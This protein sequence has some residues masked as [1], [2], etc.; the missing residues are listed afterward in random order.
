MD[1]EVA[2][3][4]KL[5]AYNWTGPMWYGGNLKDTL[6]GINQDKAFAKPHGSTHNIY[7]LV[8]HM[9][10]WRRFTLEHLKGN[11]A[12]TVE[13]NSDV[14]WP[15]HYQLNQGTWENALTQLEKNQNEL[16]DALKD[17]KDE[18]LDEL[19][20]GKKFKWYVLLHGVLHH[21]IYHSAQISLLKK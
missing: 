3:I 21:D 5:L 7:E 13:L 11:S 10:C 2:R 15:T 12:Y 1:K 20:P 9:L 16:L 4:A 6:A 17:F 8:V 19:V 18:T 14:D